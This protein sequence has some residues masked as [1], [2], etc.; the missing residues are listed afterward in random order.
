MH[1]HTYTH[2]RDTTCGATRDQQQ[3]HSTTRI[4]AHADTTHARMH[5]ARHA[6][7]PHDARSQNGRR[8]KRR[9]KRGPDSEAAV[10]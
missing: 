9:E 2:A 3:P 8:E 1:T 7:T 4:R 5:L 6:L 10:G